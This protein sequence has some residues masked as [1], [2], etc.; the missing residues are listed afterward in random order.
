MSEGLTHFNDILRGILSGGAVAELPEFMDFAKDEALRGSLQHPSSTAEVT[1]ACG[2]FM[3]FQLRLTRGV[4][5]DVRHYTDGCEAT[6]ACAAWV[7]RKVRGKKLM[8]ALDL[9]PTDVM[10]GMKNF[11]RD[12]RHCAV[13]AVVT[14]FQ[15][16]G[17][18]LVNPRVDTP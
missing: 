18:A 10:S 1:G 6:Q 4:I 7:A 17:S 12:H 11:P 9:S 5:E 3:R 13:L 16:A 8:D 15:A 2:D 14:F